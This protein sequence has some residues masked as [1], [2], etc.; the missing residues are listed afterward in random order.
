MVRGQKLKTVVRQLRLTEL[1]VILSVVFVKQKSNG[2]QKKYQLITTFLLSWR[3]VMVRWV[4]DWMT[5]A[6]S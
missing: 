1:R 6:L 4:L 5:A 3:T 2:V